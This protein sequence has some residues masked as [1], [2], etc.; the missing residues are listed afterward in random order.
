MWF[1]RTPRFSFW[2]IN[3]FAFTHRC[4]IAYIHIKPKKKYTQF[5]RSTHKIQVETMWSSLLAN[6]MPKSRYRLVLVVVY[7]LVFSLSVCYSE[8]VTSN[9]V[10]PIPN[11]S[12]TMVNNGSSTT[13]L[14][15]LQP[16]TTLPTPKITK[17][18]TISTGIPTSTTT[19]K[20]PAKIASSMLKRLSTIRP[21]VAT[22][23]A[24]GST[25]GVHSKNTSTTL[26]TEKESSR[27]VRPKSSKTTSQQQQ[28]QQQSSQYKVSSWPSKPGGTY[29]IEGDFQY[30]SR[31]IFIFLSSTFLFTL[32]LFCLPLLCLSLSL[33]LCLCCVHLLPTRTTMI[34][35]FFPSVVSLW[36]RWCLFYFCHFHHEDYVPM[37]I[38]FY[39][40][41][42]LYR[43]SVTSMWKKEA[44][45]P[46]VVVVE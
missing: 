26:N 11:L 16:T 24:S 18:T 2:A 21:N 43:S 7:Y 8:N 22:N 42:Y 6:F 28:Q 20:S 12:D 13:L 17:T 32:I 36:H 23:S 37:C 35:Y 1:G 3:L 29:L 40:L 34:R 14:L 15:L 41:V 19:V 44:R 39:R 45:T 10:E 30:N 5:A 38:L 4:R 27:N 31:Y 9:A 33:C 25:N 46:V